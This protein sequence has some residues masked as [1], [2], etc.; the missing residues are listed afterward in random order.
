[1]STW[2]AIL[3][4]FLTAVSI[5]AFGGWWFQ[6]FIHISAIFIATFKLHKRPILPP[7]DDPLPGI[8]ILKPLVGVDS[9]LYSNLETYFTLQ[10]PGQVR[11][12]V[13]CYNVPFIF[14]T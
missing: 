5:A 3:D 13:P 8:S 10:Y 14:S 7:S 9:Q 6:W 1:M 12:I 2:F 11:I 4:T